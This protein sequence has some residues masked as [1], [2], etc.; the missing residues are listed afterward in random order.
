MLLSFTVSNFRSIADKQTLNL[1]PSKKKPRYIFLN[2]GVADLGPAKGLKVKVVYGAN[3]S[4]KSNLIQALAVFRHVVI[5]SLNDEQSLSAVDPYQLNNLGEKQPTSFEIDF[6]LFGEVHSYGFTTDRSIITKEW[7]R[8][9]GPKARKCFTREKDS[10]RV[11]EKDYPQLQRVLNVSEDGESL[12]RPNALFLSFAAVVN[13]KL[14]QGIRDLLQDVKIIA[15]HVNTESLQR[16]AI[17]RI[18]QES[19][20]ARM[21]TLLR[22]A[23]IQ[24]DDISVHRQPFSEKEKIYVTH[25]HTTQT[26]GEPNKTVWVV[27][28]ESIGTQRMIYLAPVIIEALMNG[29]TLVVDEFESQLHT[30]LS[31]AIVEMFNTN[32]ANPNNAQ[33]IV[34]T[35]DTN[36]LSA[37]IL[38]RDQIAFVDKDEDKKSSVY[39]LSDFTGVRNDERYEKSYLGGGYDGLP[40]IG[41][42]KLAV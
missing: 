22:Q 25:R 42:L 11:N 17:E 34:A 1:R 41:R 20:R 12:I 6:V 9:T 18:K 30:K 21:I 14:M 39:S 32:D 8:V 16:Y 2:E 38:R 33:L 36:L 40:N 29:S 13:V 28:N 19:I 23:D 3:G 7:L 5:K 24:I 37:G 26:E 10:I 35:H 15:S 27:E 31:A 4:G